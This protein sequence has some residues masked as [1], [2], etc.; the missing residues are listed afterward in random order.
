MKFASSKESEKAYIVL[1]TCAVTRAIHLELV[2]MMDTSSF[3][4][5]LRKFFAIH[6]VSQII[7]TDNAKT[8]RRV[9]N[10]LKRIWSNI[11]SKQA[12]EYYGTRGINWRFTSEKAPWWGGF[13]ERMVRSTKERLKKT[14]GSARLDFTEM[15]TLL[16]EIASVLNSRPLTYVSENHEEFVLTPSHFLHGGRVS[17][18][19]STHGVPRGKSEADKLL[20]EQWKIRNH[21]LQEF[22]RRWYKDY[23]LTLSMFHQV[24]NPQRYEKLEVG[25]L[26]VIENENL[27][28]QCWQLGRVTTVTPGRD[29][30]IRSCLIRP[31]SGGG[32]IRRPVQRLH[33]LELE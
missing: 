27:P 13:F 6:G 3:F 2:R 21:Y 7:V 14:L 24:H 18:L 30:K 20:A 4:Q 16:Y 25:D 12:K 19:P 9:N 17:V 8:F 26:V 11:A 32:E 1:F 15:G 10:D 29:G 28:R 33:K 5:A 23:L 22:W 31:A